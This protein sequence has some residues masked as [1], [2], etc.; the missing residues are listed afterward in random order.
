MLSW[1]SAVENLIYTEVA[2]VLP[3]R[4]SSRPSTAGRG[5]PH[6]I[7]QL[8]NVNL[9]QITDIRQ[10]GTMK[11]SLPPP[12][13]ERKSRRAPV[14]HLSS[15]T[16]PFHRRG[17]GY[18]GTGRRERREAKRASKIII[19]YIFRPRHRDPESRSDPR[20]RKFRQKRWTCPGICKNT[21][22]NS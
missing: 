8:P 21:Y 10:S 6:G 16:K 18:V 4:A 5:S 1:Q 11:I 12:S 20:K 19:A 13:P 3:C 17:A 14:P 15:E 9:I 22:Y 2:V 7:R